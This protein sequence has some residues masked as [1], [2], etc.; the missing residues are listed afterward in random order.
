MRRA[1]WPQ[2][3]PS[4]NTPVGRQ[5]TAHTIVRH[6]RERERYAA[7]PL[8]VFLSLWQYR[9]LIWQMSKREVISRYRGSTLGLLWSFF[10]PLFMLTIYTFVFSVV[11]QAR[12]GR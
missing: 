7:H 4:G 3:R 2:A 5:V 11:F 10:H 1:V 9:N 8:M 12:W 6:P